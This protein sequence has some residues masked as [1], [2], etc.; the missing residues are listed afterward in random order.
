MSRIVGVADYF[1]WDSIAK[2]FSKTD[3]LDKSLIQCYFIF[4]KVEIFNN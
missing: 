1:L 4:K 3:C 2:T